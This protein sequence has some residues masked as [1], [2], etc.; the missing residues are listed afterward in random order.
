MELLSLSHRWPRAARLAGRLTLTVV[1]A[2][3]LAVVEAIEV[4]LQ[5]L[6]NGGSND[7]LGWM[8]LLLTL[9]WLIFV[10]LLWGVRWL[11]RRWPF[12]RGKNRAAIAA[13]VIGALLFPIIHIGLLCAAQVATRTTT[14]TLREAVLM[15]MFYYLRGVVHF[16]LAAAVMHAIDAS[17]LAREREVAAAELQA[18][19][20]EARL[21]TLRAQLSPHFLFNVLNA[22]AMFVRAGREAEALEILHQ[23][24]EL[25]RGFL[26][27]RQSELVTLGEEIEFAERY[28]EIQRA[29][30]E[31][32]LRVAFEVSDESRQSRV[33]SF[34]LYPLVENAVKHGLGARMGGGSISVRARTE[35]DRIVMEVED[36][37]PGIAG[38]AATGG[39]GLGLVN[40]RRRLENIYQGAA[41]VSLTAS[42]P[43]GAIARVVLPR[44]YTPTVTAA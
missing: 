29:R 1:A 28:L 42:H 7:Q 25:L 13:H 22:I 11:V 32:R 6:S 26:R 16:T 43:H 38:S 21:A 34:L 36:D 12:G 15:V 10:S 23:F 41:S 9:P 18:S 27:E 5:A 39:T 40:L 24:A 3:V 14:L 20:V 37:G 33:P 2:V 19:L 8:I 44:G 17:R 30:F 35:G 31:D 4:K